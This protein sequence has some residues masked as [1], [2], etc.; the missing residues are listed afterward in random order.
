MKS[1]NSGDTTATLEFSFRGTDDVINCPTNQQIIVQNENVA[2]AKIRRAAEPELNA[3]PARDV[4][5]SK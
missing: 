1:V 4:E 2:C 3:P 5:R